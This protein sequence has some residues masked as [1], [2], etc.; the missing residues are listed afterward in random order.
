MPAGP[1]NAHPSGQPRLLVLGDSGHAREVRELAEVYHGY[2]EVTLVSQQSESTLMA[3][4]RGPVGLGIGYPSLRRSI[5]RRWA[6]RNDLEWPTLRHPRTDVARSAT[7]GDGCVLTFGTFV[8]TDA[9]L[10]FG[11]L[12][13]WNSTIGH[14][15]TVGDYC[16]INPG[17]TVA[18]HVQLGDAVFVGTGANILEGLTIGEGAT[19]GAGAVV[20]RDIPPGVV[21][22]GVP[23]RAR[24]ATS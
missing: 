3:A 15:T 12:L 18:G 23:A 6:G 16:V 14:D 9:V 2:D 19:I 21:A 13:N 22:V 8:S 17:A 1:L 20:T 24:H 11:V 10:G 7:V 5:H 4:H